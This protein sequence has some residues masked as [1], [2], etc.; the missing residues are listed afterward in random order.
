M[1]QEPTAFGPSSLLR[2]SSGG[3]SPP[4]AA[5]ELVG[6]TGAAAGDVD[7]AASRDVSDLDK[8]DIVDGGAW[9]MGI[10]A[11]LLAWRHIGGRR[12]LRGGSFAVL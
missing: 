6:V 10:S 9:S 1:R 12:R 3:Q 2:P 7:R 5:V 8:L 11:V 4:E